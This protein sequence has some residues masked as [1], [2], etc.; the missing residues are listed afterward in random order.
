L[1]F[2]ELLLRILF[3]ASHVLIISFL[4][5]REFRIGTLAKLQYRNIKRDYQRGI[6]LIHIRVETEITKGKYHDY[7]T[8]L[9]EKAAEHPL[10]FGDRI[11]CD[12]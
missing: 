12:F 5:L 9:E 6:T 3:L 7:D 4:A 2:T 11:G 10:D 1:D 8:F